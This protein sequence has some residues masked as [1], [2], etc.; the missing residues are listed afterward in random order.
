M[1]ELCIYQITNTE[2]RNDL[3]MA[4]F[5]GNLIDVRKKEDT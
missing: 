5:Y 1:T 4:V 3:I 2:L